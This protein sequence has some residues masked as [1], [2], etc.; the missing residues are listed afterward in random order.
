[1]NTYYFYNHKK[2][3]SIILETLISS[4]SHYYS[5][6]SVVTDGKAL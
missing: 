2:I 3:L 5:E 6:I 1:M 4:I